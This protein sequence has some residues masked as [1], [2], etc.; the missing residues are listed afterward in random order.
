MNISCMQA[1]NLLM[2]QL[3]RKSRTEQGKSLDGY[4]HF[5]GTVALHG[6][7][8]GSINRNRKRSLRLRRRM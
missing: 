1:K 4:F 6:H 3:L 7:R 5:G 2:E 8:N